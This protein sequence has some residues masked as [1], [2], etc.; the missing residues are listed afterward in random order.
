MWMSLNFSAVDN[1]FANSVSYD[2]LGRTHT[3]TINVNG[4]YNAGGNIHAG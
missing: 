3:Q 1:A 2:S 4:N